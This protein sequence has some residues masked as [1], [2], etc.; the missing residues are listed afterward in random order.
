M[1][2]QALLYFYETAQHQSINQTANLCFVSASSLSRSLASL[3]KELNTTLFERTHTGIALTKADKDLFTQLKPSIEQLKQ[4]MD[5]YNNGGLN[6]Q[7]LRLRICVYQSSIV[8]QALVNFY[9]RYGDSS[10]FVDIIFDAYSTAERVL[11]QMENADYMLGMIHFPSDQLDAYRERLQARGYTTLSMP[12]LHGCIMVR[13]GH[14]LAAVANVTPEQLSAYPRVAY[15][16]EDPWELLYCSDFHNFRPKEVKKRILVTER[17]A[18][19][20]LLRHTDGYFVGINTNQL[21]VLDGALVSIPVSGMKNII[22]T[23]LFYRER[24]GL[25]ES[26]FHFIEEVQNVFAQFPD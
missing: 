20:D 25:P 13:S 26:L 19:H 12:V 2:L 22:S 15:I 17:G 5:G 23:L 1:N 10:E 8:S 6:R 24:K 21:D 3:E 9:R 4:V 16:S 11:E 18:M 7:T 14:P